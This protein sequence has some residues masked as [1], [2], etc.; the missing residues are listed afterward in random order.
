MKPV[1]LQLYSVREA[2][3]QDVVGVLRKVADM[4]YKGV[5]PAG[6]HNL[7]PRQLRETVEELGMEVTSSHGP[8][9]KPDN[10]A[11]VIDTAGDLGID[12]VATGFGPEPFSTRAYIE[13]TAQTVAAMAERLKE[14][15]LTLFIHNH[16]WE[17]AQ[18]EGRLAYDWFLDNCGSHVMFQIDAYWA[19]N[20]GAND[21]VKMVAKFAD[22][23]PLLHLKDGP[24]EKDAAMTAVG[25][26]KMDVEGVITACNPQV[27]RW[28]IVELD[29]CDTDMMQAVEQ[30]CHYLVSHGLAEGLT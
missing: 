9:A 29:R 19:A 24:L 2:A 13:E 5:E 15:G 23:T 20:H 7:T 30:S 21:P 27:L 11:E 28:I 17:F 14:A 1:A 16:Y 22:R 6:F 4:G 12:L 3:K 10:L 26:G 8:W 18:I 25:T